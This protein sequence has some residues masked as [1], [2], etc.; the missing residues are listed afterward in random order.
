MNASAKASF[1]SALQLHRRGELQ[2]AEALYRQV[3]VFEPRHAD[4][5]HMLGLLALQTGRHAMARDY[6]VRSI[7][8][9]PR[10]AEAHNHLGLAAQAL[11]QTGEAEAAFRRAI[12]LKRRLSPAWI[13]LANLL[14]TTKRTA[15]AIAGYRRAFAIEPRN[16]AAHFNLAKL[17]ADQGD[18]AG[19]E[20][21]YRAALRLHPDDAA[22][23]TAL[24]A[25]LHRGGRLDDAIAH[26][27]TA[28]ELMPQSSIALM[29]LALGLRDRGRLRDAALAALE[30]HRLTPDDFACTSLFAEC[31]KSLDPTPEDAVL[32]DHLARALAEPWDRPQQLAPVA[33]KL[34]R[35]DPASALAA[36]PPPDNPELDEVAQGPT[37]SPSHVGL[38][39]TL[40]KAAT[41]AD[42]SSERLFTGWR[43]RALRLCL[44]GTSVA[45]G[46]LRLL[47]A[48]AAQ[49]FLN[50]YAW[51][52][53]FEETQA[54]SQLLEW[55]DGAL[56]NQRVIPPAWIA[57]LASYRPLLSVPGVD[58]LLARAWP[59]EVGACV[60]QQIEEPRE[61]IQAQGQLPRLTPIQDRT[62]A[63]VRDQYESNPYPRWSRTIH[64]LPGGS[65][66]AVLR[67]AVPG[68]VL[69]GD[70][71]ATPEILVAGCGT[72]QHAIETARRFANSRVLA[73]DLSLRSLAYAARKTREAGIATIEY[74]QADILELADLG[75]CF[76]VV[77]ASGV[78]HHLEV[79]E[80]GWR[81]LV[82]LLRPG[83][84]MKVGL[85]SELARAPIARARAAIAA[86]GYDASAE[87]I[88][89]FREEMADFLDA[90]AVAA[91]RASAD[92]YSIS[93]C[94]DLMFH[95]QEHRFTLPEIADMIARLGVEFLG[96]ELPPT[97]GPRERLGAGALAR[98][99]EFE[100]THPETFQGM[101]QFWVRRRAS[102]AP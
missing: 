49:C 90:D 24:A 101:Y 52:E 41:I 51:A 25:L 96:F 5:L 60:A 2:Q 82:S 3:L 42:V 59:A 23:H 4:A 72:G 32:A 21:H 85:Y 7:A 53:T 57:L 48:L 87:G 30:A 29:N 64:R 61:E 18:A 46:G 16:A 20:N 92:F 94:R 79:P 80:A 99:H 78:L 34:L 89:R 97:L 93:G 19:A 44:A 83:G 58:R 12:E 17:L 76:D 33:L 1:D 36:D 27:R 86:H 28:T 100:R 71:P 50:E 38:L 54:L 55:I 43:K 62:S 37:G 56:V 40:L 67:A 45:A 13:N 10:V 6:I 73:V 98:W 69:D 75:R 11:G 65:V 68:L 26:Y 63:Q 91:L 77:E 8:I 74:A 31:M 35:A 9:A 15:E 102:G 22:G 70:G 66:H 39:L 14:A 81:V 88:R 47:C 84:F 95:V